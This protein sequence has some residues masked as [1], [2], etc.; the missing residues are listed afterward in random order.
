M[1]IY[2]LSRIIKIIAACV[3]V[4]VPIVNFVGSICSI[5]SL[6]R[7]EKRESKGKTK[8]TSIF[9]GKT[10]HVKAGLES[11][12]S[13]IVIGSGAGITVLFFIGGKQGCSSGKVFLLYIK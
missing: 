9:Q 2:V 10:R 11:T 13:E 5:I 8:L 12:Y 4:I 6:L 3:K 1:C 7:D